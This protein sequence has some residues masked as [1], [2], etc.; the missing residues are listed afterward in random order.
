MARR[1]DSFLDRLRHR[2][3]LGRWARAARAAATS[4]LAALR[5]ERGRARQIR[6]EIDR[7]LFQADARLTRPFIGSDV[8]ANPLGS[9][10][11]WRPELWRGP[12]SPSGCAAAE[13]KTQLGDQATLFHDC[14]ESE[15]TLRQVR[16]RRADDL[17]PFGLKLDVLG[18]D[19]SFLS[20]VIDL[21]E[22]AEGLKRRHI[23]RLSTII[24]AEGPLEVFARLNVKHGPNT[25]QILRHLPEGDSERVAEFDLGQSRLQENRVERAWLDL[26]F[27]APRMN[28]VLL[29]DLTMSR[30]PRADL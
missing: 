16:N 28:A 7:L 10:W 1:G 3:V 5:A 30:R 19:G 27:E 14:R 12:V 13:T 23:L 29:R 22:A 15:I 24:E 25:E 18:F 26:I 11:V 2:R 6:R 4:D 8:I 17:A 20:L 21:P 9:D